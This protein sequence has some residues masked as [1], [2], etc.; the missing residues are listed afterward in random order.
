MGTFDP[1]RKYT[2]D[3]VAVL[4][5]DLFRKLHF[6]YMMQPRA[7]GTTRHLKAA[8]T[9]LFEA[10]ATDGGLLNAAAE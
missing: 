6:D 5:P 3:E 10:G 9:S 7:W 8:S 4:D 1:G 2:K